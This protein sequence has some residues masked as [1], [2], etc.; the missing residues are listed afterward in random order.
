MTKAI[1]IGAGFSCDLGMPSAAQ[2]SKTFFAYFNYEK[3]SKFIIPQIEYFKPYG[4]G[5]DL[6]KEA[7][8]DILEVFKNNK[9][10]NYERFIKQIEQLEYK[11]LTPN[12]TRTI[13]YF[14]SILYDTIYN[15]FLS[16]HISKY[17]IYSIM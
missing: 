5:I 12:Y 15:F 1:L 16:F 9:E 17:P 11:R 10:D 3:V 7:F 4:K 2:L 6:S 14:I 8:N 13:H